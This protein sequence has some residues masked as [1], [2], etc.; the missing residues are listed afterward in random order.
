MKTLMNSKMSEGS[1]VRDHCLKIISYLNELEILGATVD[2]ETQVD[3]LL[4]TLP[5]SFNQFK[6]NY[7]MNKMTLSLPELMKKLQAAEGILRAK[8]SI[9]IAKVGTSLGKPK[10]KN[11]KKKNNKKSANKNLTPSGRVGKKG[12]KAKPQG[13]CFHCGE[14]GRWK[15]NCPT[16]LAKIKNQGM[17]DC[18]INQIG[19]LGKCL[20]FVHETCFVGRSIESWCVK[21]FSVLS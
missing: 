3:M 6:L 9:H 5:D 18:L 11:Q 10:G 7:N 4:E 12:T 21:L 8:G 20:S 15:R 14:K 17:V 1:S 16:Y 19:K 13:K 2:R